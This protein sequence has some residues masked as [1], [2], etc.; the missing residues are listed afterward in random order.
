M[1]KK[2]KP[3]P[4][5]KSVNLVVCAV[6]VCCNYCDTTGPQDTGGGPIAAWNDRGENNPIAINKET[7]IGDILELLR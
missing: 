4:F 1:S 7:T 6:H 3:C 2:L 5:C